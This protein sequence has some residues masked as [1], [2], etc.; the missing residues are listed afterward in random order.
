M[1]FTLKYKNIDVLKMELSLYPEGIQVLDFIVI[2]ENLLPMG[3]TPFLH[4]SHACNHIY[5]LSG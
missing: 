2:N 5:C 4:T 3:L 1:K